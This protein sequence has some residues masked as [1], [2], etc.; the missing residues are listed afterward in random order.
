[1]I[2]LL[3]GWTLYAVVGFGA[4]FSLCSAYRILFGTDPENP[5]LYYAVTLFGVIGIFALSVVAVVVLAFA[6]GLATFLLVDLWKWAH[7]D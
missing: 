4:A 5:V 6:A 7:N 3:T 1:M 2:K